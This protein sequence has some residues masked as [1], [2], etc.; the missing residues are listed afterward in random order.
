MIDELI[1]LGDEVVITIPKETRDA[2]YNP[3]PDGT[4]AVVIGFSETY[5]GRINNFGYA[6]G[7]YES[8]SSAKLRLATEQRECAEP[9]V[10]FTLADE[11][12]YERRVT[13]F[14]LLQK[15]DPDNWRK[16]RFL[17]EL[18]ETP[19]WE[20]DFVQVSRRSIVTVAYGKIPPANDPEVFQVIGI[21]YCNLTE[22]TRSGTKYP[23]YLISDGF[24]AG[25]HTSA[26]EDN[27]A[28]VERGPV[29]KYY[30]GEPIAFSDIQEEANFFDMLGHT[31][32]VRNP[33]GLYK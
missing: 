3:C 28:L 25:W 19:F 12:E 30:H 15:E 16:K 18:P 6:P 33:N 8:K 31:R 13:A 4:S 24:T 9:S 10:Y 29:W 22:L 1:E 5:Y 32:Q 23:A 27:M 20:G 21:A 14:R 11:A 17:R 7:V 26:S 2:G